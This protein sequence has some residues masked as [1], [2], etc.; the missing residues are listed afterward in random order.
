[1]T[2][3]ARGDGMVDIGPLS[4]PVEINATC[5]FESCP[6]W[7]AILKHIRLPMVG[8]SRKAVLGGGVVASSVFQYGKLFVESL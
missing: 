4:G 2:P 5:R 1:M 8:R 3:M 6:Q 7:V